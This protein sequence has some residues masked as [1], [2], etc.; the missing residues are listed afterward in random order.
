VR[1]RRI[2]DELNKAI[3]SS[4]FEPLKKDTFEDDIGE[5]A[6]IDP[7]E[8]TIYVDPLDGTREF[9]KERLENC[10]VLVGIAIGGESVAG[11]IGYV[12][13]QRFGAPKISL[14]QIHT[15]HLSLYVALLLGYPSQVATWIPI[16]P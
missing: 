9:V 12:L 10:Q 13:F 6:E 11:A 3:S 14:V 7:S 8:I 16:L 1:R 15:Y 5:T 4:S 2:Y